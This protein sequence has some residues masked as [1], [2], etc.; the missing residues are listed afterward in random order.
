MS[1][2]LVFPWWCLLLLQMVSWACYKFGLFPSWTRMVGLE[3]IS[4]DSFD[5]LILSDAPGACRT[6]FRMFG[7]AAAFLFREINEQSRSDACPK[8]IAGVWPCIGER[9]IFH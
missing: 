1:I 2:L 9:S 8:R 7:D 4:Q 6:Y 3:K 5:H